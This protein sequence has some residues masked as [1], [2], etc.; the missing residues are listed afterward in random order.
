MAE[1]SVVKLNE[2]SLQRLHEK[3]KKMKAE[4]DLVESESSHS[5]GVDFA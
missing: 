5:K 1:I 4:D 3:L 2:A